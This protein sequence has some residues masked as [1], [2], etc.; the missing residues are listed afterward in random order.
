[1]GIVSS[2]KNS[3]GKDDVTVQYQ[4]SNASL[5]TL[6]RRRTRD[7]NNKRALVDESAF[8]FSVTNKGTSS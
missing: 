4:T 1:V 7:E 2:R 8:L 5:V 3:A 6:M